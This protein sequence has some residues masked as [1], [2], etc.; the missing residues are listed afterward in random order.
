MQSQLAQS[1]KLAS[2]GRLTA[3]VA[4]EIN[5]PIQYVGDNIR[6]LQDAFDDLSQ[7]LGKYTELLDA[8]KTSVVP[9]TLIREVE[10]AVEKA[11][12]AYLTEEIPTAIQQS[13]EG[14][15][16]VTKIVRAMKELSYPDVEEKTPIDIN[17]AIE[18]TITVARNEWKYVAELETDFDSNLPLVPCL[19]GE[20]N[21][22]ILNLLTNAAHAIADVVGDGCTGK[23]TITIR[24]RCEGDWAE[25]RVSDTGTG[26]PEEIRSRIFEPFFTT[27]EVG[28]GTGQGLV[29]ARS[30][31][32]DKHSGTF[33]FETEVG[34][35]T[36]FIIRLPIADKFA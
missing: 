13:L 7:L 32:V 27:K 26:I 23:G 31:I 20:F 10:A 35:G 5:T 12:L 15:A 2:I 24:T 19:P 30:V 33:D 1:Q 28:K 25:V 8:I 3:G 6:F 11:D 18:S 29:I 34:A 21:Q 17:K 36:T 14:V 9:D 4:H 22:V 16:H